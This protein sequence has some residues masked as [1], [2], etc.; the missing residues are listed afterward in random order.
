M[1]QKATAPTANSVNQHKSKNN[2]LISVA[3]LPNEIFP[4]IHIS[5]NR[6]GPLTTHGTERA[7]HSPGTVEDHIRGILGEFA[8]ADMFQVPERID[9]SLYEYGDPGFD[10]KIN[11]MRIDVKTAGPRVNNPRLMV[12]EK[13][14]LKADLYVL[15]QELSSRVYR[16]LGYAPVDVVERAPV[17]KFSGRFG[18][19]RVRIVEQDQLAPLPLSMVRNLQPSFA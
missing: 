18:G 10:L 19:N 14:E 8:V 13:D 11:G 9:T 16:V 4:T 15:V 12:A 6:Y 7:Y 3:D 2:L 5:D 1:S 17:S